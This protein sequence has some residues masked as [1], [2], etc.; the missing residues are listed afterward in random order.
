MNQLGFYF[1][2]KIKP[3]KKLKNKAPARYLAGALFF[4]L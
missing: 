2:L 3:L 4:K 1:R